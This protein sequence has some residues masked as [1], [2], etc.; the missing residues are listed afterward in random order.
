MEEFDYAEAIQELESI[1]TRMEDPSVG[2]DEIDRNISRS[3]EL[4]ALCRE[5]L[6]GAREK[7]EAGI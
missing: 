2:L 7:V 4:I 6:R 3:N 1:A 5:Y